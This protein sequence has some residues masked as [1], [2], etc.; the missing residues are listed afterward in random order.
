[1]LHCNNTC[2]IET[3]LTHVNYFVAAQHS[4]LRISS[5]QGY[6]NIIIGIYTNNYPTPIRRAL[7][8]RK[9]IYWFTQSYSIWTIDSHLT[10]YDF[11]LPCFSNCGTILI[12]QNVV[13]CRPY[14]EINPY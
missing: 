5:S 9:H 7:G 1:M 12:S 8:S 3:Y 14:S 4:A 6:R 13:L 2:N 10:L 11:K